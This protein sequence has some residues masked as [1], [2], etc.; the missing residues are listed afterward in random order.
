MAEINVRKR[1]KKWE[2]RFEAAKINGRRNQISKGGFSTKKEALQEG[3]KALNQYNNSGLAFEPSEISVSDYLNYWF[4]TFCKTNLK[5]NTQVN[6]LQII[7]NHLIPNFGMYK[8]KALSSSVLQEYANKLK[9]CGY[10][11]S[12]VT[13]ILITF[14]T[15]LDYAVEPL[16]Y[17]SFNPIKLIKFPKIEKKKRERIILTSE[18]YNKIITRF[19][20]TR[21]YIPIAI[22]FFTGIRISE[23]F[24]LTWD[25][26]DFKNR[27]ITINKQII[28]RN[29]GNDVRKV[30][31]I[32]GKKELKSAWYFSDV[33][34][35]KSNRIIKFG[36]N[37][38]NILAEE[39]NLQEKKE[40]EY[41]NFFTIYVL[42][43]EVDEKNNPI[44]RLLPIQKCIP[45]TLPRA[46]LICINE[47]GEL[48]TPDSF[49]Y[50]SKVIHY[51]LNIAFD[52]HS[53]RH[54]HATLL[55]ENGANIKDVQ[56]R[57]GHENI[58]TTLQTYVHGTELLSNKSVEIF[59]NLIDTKFK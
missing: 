55:I 24:G 49:K 7:N 47:N 10:S 14:S 39:K 6:Y 1:G 36:N 12:H 18:E 15:A 42:K 58:E 56:L 28:K 44:Y 38:Y 46:K 27:T 48:T 3:T 8:L 40:K 59:D 31:N 53:L 9:S 21:F 32:K 29:F 11:K 50:C 43:K 22:G 4:G 33:K 19:K 57:L 25:D 52:Y 30:V 16:Q 17:I 35:P 37:L 20:N 13:G 5:Y 51:D 45:S 26:V 23:C 2:Y 34:T 41:G 54:T